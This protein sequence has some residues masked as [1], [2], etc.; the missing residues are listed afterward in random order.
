M[1][2]M[3]AKSARRSYLNQAKEVSCGN[4][5]VTGA[6]VQKTCVLRCIVK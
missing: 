5:T 2:A 4:F 3:P 1:P 6:K